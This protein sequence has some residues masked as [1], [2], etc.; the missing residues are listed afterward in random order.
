MRQKKP[1]FSVSLLPQAFVVVLDAK[2]NA[3]CNQSA[4]RG[5]PGQMI[6]GSRQRQE[7][8]HTG[9]LFLCIFCSLYIPIIVSSSSLS[10][11]TL[12]DLHPSPLHPPLG[13][14]LTLWLLVLARL[15]TSSSAEAQP[16]SPSRERGSNGRK[17][18]QR[19][20]WFTC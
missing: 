3:C 5:L 20:S 18:R 1:F 2:T 10:S 13:Y 17:Q 12:T 9:L 16:G 4:H 15:G 19:R 8:E 7:R 11:P 14:H 6:I